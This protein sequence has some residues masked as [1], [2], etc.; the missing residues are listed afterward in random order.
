MRNEFLRLICTQSLPRCLFIQ[1]LF[2]SYKL[3][4]LYIYYIH[5]VYLKCLHAASIHTIYVR[6]AANNCHRCR[7]PHSSSFLDPILLL[8]L[9]FSFIFIQYMYIYIYILIYTLVGP[10]RFINRNCH[11]LRS[12]CPL[13]L[14]TSGTQY[15]FHNDASPFGFFISK[16]KK[17]IIIIK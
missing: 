12:L 2:N 11:G 1:R 6:T 3:L 8:L 16:E 7:L 9:L 17:N 15:H 10:E 4:S 14:H 13:F 5:I